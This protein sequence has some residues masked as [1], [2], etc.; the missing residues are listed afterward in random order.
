MATTT[1]TN[2][3]R[4]PNYP[5]ISLAEA[6]ERLKV[7][8][9]SQRQYPATREV[10]ARLMGYGG[11]NGASSAVVSALSKYGLIEGHNDNL[12]VSA[13]GQDLV[14]HRKGDPEYSAALKT[15]AFMPS[16]FRELHEQYSQGLPS[17]H[18]LRATLIKRGFNPKAIDSAVRAYRDTMELLEAAA[19]NA[20]ADSLE[21]S[22]EPAAQGPST[23]PQDNRNSILSNPSSEPGIK[24]VHLPL[25]N[26]EWAIL[27]APFP[28]T[29]LAWN[30]MTAVLTAMKPALVVSPEPPSKHEDEASVPVAER[31]ES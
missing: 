10:L 4:S 8:Y 9:E 13:V 18:S 20:D 16:F 15:A 28:L 27:Q 12:R 11:L 21:E 17:D 22:S 2:K 7:V 29:E 5:A 3:T 19:G 14:L 24:T 31:T 1:S 23:I 6:V 30:Q 26:A 25:S